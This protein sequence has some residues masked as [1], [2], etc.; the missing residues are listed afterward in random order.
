M[1]RYHPALQETKSFSLQIIPVPHTV[2]CSGFDLSLVFLFIY[3]FIYLLTNFLS[4]NSHTDMYK[5]KVCSA[6]T[7]LA[8]AMK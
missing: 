8:C 7:E 3:F 4:Y 2:H 5:F 6:M 1:R